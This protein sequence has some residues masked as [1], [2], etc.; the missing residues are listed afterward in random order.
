MDKKNN[1]LNNGIKTGFILFLAILLLCNV[2]SATVYRWVPSS[3]QNVATGITTNWGTCGDTATSY[4]KTLLTTA[5][6]SGC[7]DDTYHQ[8]GAQDP[9]VDMFFN[10]AYTVNTNVQGNWYYGRLKD[11]SRVSDDIYTFRIIYANPDGTL[12]ILPGNG[13][14]TI[15]NSGNVDLN[16]NISLTAIS[17]TVPAGA[18]LGLRISKTGNSLMRIYFG[19]TA[20]LTNKPSGYFSVSETPSGDSTPPA[21]ITALTNITNTQ[22]SINWTWADPADTDFA[23]VMIYLNG[24]FKTNVT[25]GMQYN[26]TTGLNYNTTYELSTHTVDATGN[27]NQTWVNKTSKTS[28]QVSPVLECVIDNGDSTYTAYFGYNNPNPYSVI[29]P[30][31]SVY[32]ENKFNPS[33]EDR[34]QPSTFLPG[35]TPYYPNAAFNVVFDGSNLVWSLNGKTSTASS[36]STKCDNIPPVI[37]IIS[38]IN[39]IYSTTSISLDVSANEPI[40]TWLYSLNSAPNVT[41]TP[42]TT[43]TAVVGSNSIIVYANDTKNNWNSSSVDF[44]VQLPKSDQTITFGALS[45]KTYGD[46]DFTVSATASSGLAVIFSASGTCTVTGSSVHITGAGSCTIT[47]NQS[48]N[49]SYNAA[50]DVPQSFTITLASS[51]VTVTCPA[52]ATYTGSAIEPCTASYSGAGGLSGSLTPT[53]TSNVNNGT[54]TANATYAGDTN[55]AGSS[56]SA[57]FEITKASS[58][59]AVTC[60]AS[61]TYTGSA[62]TPCSVT[63]TGAGGLSLTPAPVYSNNTNAGTATASYYYFGYPNHYDSSDSKNFAITKATATISLSGLSHLYDGTPKSAT[64]TTNPPGL[65]VVSITYNG[66]STAPT[67]IGS[68]AVVATLTNDNYAASPMTGTLVI[69][70]VPKIDQT[71]TFGALSGKTYGDAAFDVSATAS[72]G[73]P[74]SFSIVSENATIS[75]STITITGAGTVTVRA[76]QAGNDTYNAAANVD[77]VFTV[78]KATPIITWSNPA[79]ITYGTALSGTQLNAGASLSGTFVYTPPATTVLSV[80]AGQTLHVAFTPTDTA[81]YNSTSKNVTINVV[82]VPTYSV[83]GYVLNNPGAGLGGVLVQ[84]GSNIATT[85]TNGSYS[86]TGL[87]NGLY[88]FS[89]TKADFARSYL[90]VTVS[91]ADVTNANKTL[92]SLPSVRYINGTVIDSGISHTPLAGVTVS[93]TG[94]STVTDGSGKYSLAVVSGSYPLTASYDIRYYTNSSVTVSTAFDAVVN[95]VIVLQ[96]KPVGTISGTVSVGV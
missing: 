71:I 8:S 63:V 59:V 58:S 48:G 66:S 28:L 72:S 37:T 2:A 53:Y 22:T 14:V 96:L 9:A 74:V 23:K 18:K 25:K 85:A 3:G 77:Q 38:P 90:E 46:A 26:Y 10:T 35:R 44:T 15:L 7:S 45:T 6:T 75:G 27:V 92:T 29:I 51:S 73:L 79:D 39:T 42:G 41:F 19:D 60:P 32:P 86:I 56:N 16:Y 4:A 65:T 57:N 88:N 40:S 80:G 78:N 11:T 47:A 1:N 62:I 67:A 49:A 54:A 95:Q 36:G 21:S 12:G 68:Y 17:G 61:A 33:P 31:G 43:I 20:N 52:S 24:I 34:G 55:H 89:Y 83:S 93:T 84:N 50:P 82:S 64:A 5:S 94:A 81:N 87:L 70:S 91:G 13:S 76:S 69:S 30:V